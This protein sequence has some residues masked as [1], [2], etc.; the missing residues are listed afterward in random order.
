MKLSGAE[1]YVH[2]GIFTYIKW[3][4]IGIIINI[5]FVLAGTSWGMDRKLLTFLISL[6]G[7]LANF[8]VFEIDMNF[9]W[10]K[11]IGNVLLSF[12]LFILVL[13]FSKDRYKC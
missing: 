4:I 8:L 6:F 9:L 12:S 7:V 5:G 10:Q 11:V 3:G 2:S 13:F 1:A